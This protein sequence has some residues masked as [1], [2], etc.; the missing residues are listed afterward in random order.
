MATDL[1]WLVTDL[2]T[3]LVKDEVAMASF[4]WNDVLNR[5]G[6]ALGTARLEHRSSTKLN[7]DS[8][9]SGLWLL[10]NGDIIFGGVM[11]SVSPR[12]SSRVLQVPVHGFM[13]Y[14]EQRLIRSKLGMTYTTANPDP[15]A[16]QWIGVDMFR[17]VEDIVKHTNA[18]TTGDIGLDI[19]Y[20]ALL[21]TT[22]DKT[23]YTYEFKPAGIA[24]QQ[25]ADISPGFWWHYEYYWDGQ[26][27][28]CRI[29]L[30]PR[31]S[32]FQDIPLEYYGSTG[33]NV[34][35]VDSDSSPQPVNGVAAVGQ[36]EGSAMLTA[37][38]TDLNTG[39]PLYETM[40]SFKDVSVVSTLNGHASAYLQR[41]KNARS[42]LQ[43]SIDWTKQPKPNETRLGDSYRVI[44]DDYW[45]QYNSIYYVFEKSFV[46]SDTG[47][48]DFK[49]ALEDAL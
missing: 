30:R 1:T 40:L 23:Y 8:W 26:K 10:L 34:T 32:V 33:T 45:M 6:A 28:A 47:D 36:G 38:R 21:G 46:V 24:I 13:W 15:Y 35:S 42:N 48:L 31:A 12:A 9:R 18:V 25:L 20:D 29:R 44:I 37:Y 27:P 43:V 14:L 4:N 17:I 5:P 41:Q 2:R 7:F 49:M 3:G 16:I 39:N 19:V 11:G 22:T